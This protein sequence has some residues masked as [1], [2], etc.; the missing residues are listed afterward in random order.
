MLFW[1]IT[2]PS[3]FPKSVLSFCK[4]SVNELKVSLACGFRSII[5][6]NEKRFPDQL[7][8][9][10][11]RSMSTDPLALEI[12]LISKNSF[13]SPGKT[14]P[15]SER[16]IRGEVKFFSSADPLYSEEP[17]FP[18]KSVKETELV[19]YRFPDPF[20][21]CAENEISLKV[22]FDFLYAILPFFSCQ[23]ISTWG[24][25]VRF[26]KPFIVLFAIIT[27]EGSYSETSFMYFS[28]RYFLIFAISRLCPVTLRSRL[29]S[30]ATNPSIPKSKLSIYNVPFLNR[31]PA[32]ELN[33]LRSSLVAIDL[34]VL[35]L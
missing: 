29:L 32:V 12:C 34:S 5:S 3:T 22:I 7:L 2:V 4:P 6:F 1:I 10:S 35:K 31:I 15:L 25:D 20:D 28:G 26:N 11:L 14:L 24:L 21:K 16:S 17:S 19:I 23:L 30:E 13:N 9:I 18:L 33:K 8:L 27:P